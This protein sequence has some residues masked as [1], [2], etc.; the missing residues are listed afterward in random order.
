MFFVPSSH[1][2]SQDD[3]GELELSR[4]GEFHFAP[5]AKTH[6]ARSAEKDNFVVYEALSFLRKP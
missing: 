5:E 3:S 2:S 1:T 6:K 4:T